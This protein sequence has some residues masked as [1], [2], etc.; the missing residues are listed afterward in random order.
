MLNR[1][2]LI[3]TG[4]AL[5][6]AGCGRGQRALYSADAH[7]SDYPT[8]QGVQAMADQVA[9]RTGG[10]IE[11]KIFAGGQLGSERD[12]LEL[13]VFGALDL[14][15]VNLAPLNSI[16]PETVVPALPF[17]FNSI[18]HMRR[19]LDGAPGQT[20][21]DALMPHD[22]VGLCFYDS[23]ARSFYNTRGPIH[24]PADLSGL[25]IR[26]PN[27]DVYVAMVAA[28]G[29]NATPM[30]FGEVYQGLVQGVIDGAENNWPS[31]EA[32]RHFEAAR[33]ISLTRHVMAPEVLC[34]SRRS[35][36]RLS[37]EDQDIVRQAARDSVPVMR[38]LW[39]ARVDA[40]RERV[41]AAGIEANEVNDI[42][43]FS[44]RMGDVWDRFVTSDVQRRLVEDIRNLGGEV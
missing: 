18:P 11:I 42:S 20:I 34:M 24:E 19:S 41:L 16:A 5:A 38:E 33:Y 6:V 43:A 31:Y 14:N 25:K 4:A 44:E 40:S 39:D 36:D 32:T 7:A 15:R 27:S 37:G 21:L 8:V 2:H 10:R 30:A 17:L 12:T 29:A 28:L 1:R 9:E 13:T 26:V 22:L 35:W 23:G 3:A